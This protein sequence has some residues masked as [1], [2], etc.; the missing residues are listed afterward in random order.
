M[1]VKFNRV[2]A[3]ITLAREPDPALLEDI[4]RRLSDILGKEVI[5]HVRRDPAILG[6][7]LVRVGDR[8]MD[9]TLRRKI[10]RLRRQ[11]LGT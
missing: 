3:G 2:H 7:I 10:A 9:G 11:M 6:G 5:P 1:D 8:V 4:R